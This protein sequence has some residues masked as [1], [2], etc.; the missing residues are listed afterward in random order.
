MFINIPIDGMLRGVSLPV[1]WVWPVFRAEP[2]PEDTFKHHSLPF[3]PGVPQA[4]FLNPIPYKKNGFSF[5]AIWNSISA[6][7]GRPGSLPFAPGAPSVGYSIRGHLKLVL[8][9]FSIPVAPKL[10]AFYVRMPP[11]PCN[12]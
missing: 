6:V 2:L 9:M 1:V 8:R 4:S 7:P 3:A 11:H 10:A 5:E 12:I